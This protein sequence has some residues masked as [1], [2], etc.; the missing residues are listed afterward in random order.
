[1]IPVVQVFLIVG[2]FVAL[3]AGSTLTLSCFAFFQ[4]RPERDR[5]DRL[6]PFVHR[7]DDVDSVQDWLDRQWETQQ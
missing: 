7:G 2:A 1:M 3:W 5:V 6:R 4:R